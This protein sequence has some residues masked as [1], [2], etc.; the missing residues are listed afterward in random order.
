MTATDGGQHTFL[1]VGSVVAAEFTGRLWMPDGYRDTSTV[2]RGVG[3][4]LGV[5]SAFNLLREFSPE[6]KRVFTWR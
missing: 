3:L 2:M 4:Q 5:G 1:K 6:L